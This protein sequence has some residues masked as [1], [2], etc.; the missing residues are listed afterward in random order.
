[1]DMITEE[2][3]SNQC[4]LRIIHVN[5]VYKLDNLSHF[6][7]CKKINAVDANKIIGILAGD[8][9]APSLLSSLDSGESMVMCMNKAG[10]DYICIGNHESDILTKELRS[11]IA[12]SNFTWINSNMPTFKPVKEEPEKNLPEYVIVEVENGN[13]RV[14]LLG[15][16]LNYPD[17]LKKGS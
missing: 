14:A 2:G 5:D 10:I 7:S 8:F 4:V 6:A 16:T 11:R 15:L 1:M 17:T 9:L 12:Q 13:R 3:N